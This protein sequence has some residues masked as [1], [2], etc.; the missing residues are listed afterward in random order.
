MVWLSLWSSIY[1]L[2]VQTDVQN[3]PSHLPGALHFLIMTKQLKE[4]I[5]GTTETHP[6][7]RPESNPGGWAPLVMYNLCSV[8]DVWHC[9]L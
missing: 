2:D 7:L 8:Q 9:N 3:I 6:K 4:T 5:P 1:K